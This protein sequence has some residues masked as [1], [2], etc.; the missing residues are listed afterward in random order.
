MGGNSLKKVV[1]KR[2]DDDRYK[3]VSVEV[4]EILKKY[5]INVAI[6]YEKPGKIDHGDIDFICQIDPSRGVLDP[7][8]ELNSIECHRNGH[9][10]SFEY[11]EHQIDMILVKTSEEFGFARIFY[12]YGDTGMLLGMICKVFG[13]VMGHSQL[14]IEIPDLPYNGQTKRFP[15]TTDPGKM[16]NF[17]GLSTKIREEKFETVDDV[18]Q[19]ISTCKYYRPELFHRKNG[20][21]HRKR[22]LAR[23]MYVQFVEF[24]EN[25][26]N[27]TL[28][29]LQRKMVTKEKVLQD[30]L[31]FFDKRDEFLELQKEKELNDLVREKINGR[32]IMEWTGVKGPQIGKILSEIFSKYD[33]KGILQLSDEELHKIACSSL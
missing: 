5:Y 4:L 7:V 10:V 33:K 24:S 30:A 21:R 32:K 1:A 6:P 18:F 20:I 25:L 3:K 13:I 14:R 8:K 15:L 27:F 28:D 26:Q 23:P 12:S 22:D 31:L 2:L 11:E 17:L 19:W 29:V 16:I 9:V